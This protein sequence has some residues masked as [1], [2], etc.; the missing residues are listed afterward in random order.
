MELG[1]WL[2]SLLQL[3]CMHGSSRIL[4]GSL[5]TR[6]MGALK[7]WDL[8]HQISLVQIYKASLSSLQEGR[9]LGAI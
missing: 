1:R 6:C 9:A 4:D 2:G 3:V 5:S 7:S 8:N